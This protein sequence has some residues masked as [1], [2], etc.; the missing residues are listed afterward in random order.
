MRKM[1][2]INE[3]IWTGNDQS[4]L[5]KKENGHGPARKKSTR[6]SDEILRENFGRER[7]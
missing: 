3:T 1:T 2:S 6:P 7:G 5:E 4:H